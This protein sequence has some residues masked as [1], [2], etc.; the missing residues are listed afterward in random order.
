MATMPTTRG[1][2]S[3]DTP[4]WPAKVGPVPE[5]P[6]NI[7]EQLA[8]AR[9]LRSSTATSQGAPHD[10]TELFQQTKGVITGATALAVIGAPSCSPQVRRSLETMSST[11]VVGRSC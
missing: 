10:I 7:V 5:L 11:I 3:G 2:P 9:Q 6:G 1:S 4:L 8:E